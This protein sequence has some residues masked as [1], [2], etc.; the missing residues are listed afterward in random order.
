[1]VKS[2]NIRGVNSESTAGEFTLAA[3]VNKE[4]FI[5]IIVI[6]INRGNAKCII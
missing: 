3:S 4:V 1:M 2:N 5:N 6:M